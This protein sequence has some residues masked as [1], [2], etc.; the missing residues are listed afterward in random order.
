MANDTVPTTLKSS[1]EYKAFVTR[2]AVVKRKITLT[3]NQV[4]AEDSAYSFE[5]FISII[6]N[7]LLDIKALDEQINNLLCAFFEEDEDSEE[8]NTELDNQTKYHLSTNEKLNKLKAHVIDNSST[9]SVAGTVSDCNLKLPDLKCQCFSGEGTNELEFHSFI[10]QFNNVIGFRANL[11]NATKLT[12]LRTYLKGYALKTIQHLQ[13]CNANYSVV[14]DLL[15]KEFL[16]TNAL[17]D[18]LLKKFFELKPKSDS[19]FTEL[20]VFINEVRCILSDLKTYDYDCIASKPANKVVSHSVFHKLPVAFKQELVRKLGNNYPSITD[21]FENYVEVVRV[22]ELQS[23]PSVNSHAKSKCSS[24]VSSISKSSIV[25]DSSSKFAKFCKFCS[26]TGHSMLH[27]QK[28]STFL[29]RKRRCDE[30]NMCSKCSSQRHITSKCNSKLDYACTSCSSHDHI[31]ALC[32]RFAKVN[33]NFCVNSAS[34]AGRTFIL[35]TINVKLRHGKAVTSV[36]CLVD[37]GS[38]RSYISSEVLQRL[39]VSETLLNKTNLIINTFIDAASKQFSETSLSVTLH[40]NKTFLLPFLIN[41]DI[42]LS[43]TIHGL[44]QAHGNIAS[45]YN[46][47]E[48]EVNSDEVVLEGLLGV[49]ALQCLG[50]LKIVPCLGGSAFKV[51]NK[52]VPF[53]NVDNFL[54]SSQLASKYLANTVNNSVN[55]KL[56]VVKI[57][58]S[59][60]NFVVNPTKS[61]FDPI[62]SVI[63]DSAVE[64]SLDQLFSVE[65]LGITDNFCDYDQQQIDKFTEGITFKNNYYYVSLPWTEKLANVKSNFHVIRAILNKVVEKLHSSD[66]YDAYHEIIQQQ[67]TDGILEP[68]P[69][70]DSKLNEQVFIPHRPVIKYADQVTTKIRI[71][72]NCSL[73]VDSSPSLNEAAYKGVNLMGDLLQLLIKIRSND[74]LVMADVRQAFL[75][76]KLNSDFDK[77]KFTILWISPDGQLVSYRYTSLVFGF[78][79][80]PFILNHVIKY[81]VANYPPDDCSQILLSN[82]YVDNLFYTGHSYNELHELYTQCCERMAKGGFELRSWMSNHTEL[83]SDFVTDGKAVVHSCDYEKVLGY[84]YYPNTDQLALSDF[85]DDCNDV[86]I[87]KRSVLSYISRVFDP[88]GL[89]LPVTVMGK[90]FVQNLWKAKLSWDEILSPE[91]IKDWLK[92]K[93]ELDLLPQVKFA[94]KGYDQT[95]SSGVKLLICC[96]SSREV[97]GFSCY[98]KTETCSLPN[99]IFAKAKV[100]PLKTKTLPT[101]E[102]MAVY[103]GLRCLPSILSALCNRVRDVVFC[104]DAQIV[105]SWI[106]STYVKTKNVFAKNRVKDISDMRAEIRTNRN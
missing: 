95:D 2:R 66:I 73:K 28:Y 14:I 35:P 40:A 30:L 39:K 61:Y 17:T 88:M 106:L 37:T 93:S 59:I 90:I 38:Q 85:K 26:S 68:V 4:E 44:K 42:N 3:F 27:C 60:V 83:R 8:C 78:I 29:Q 34:D 62:G 57:D 98:A 63:T 56:S 36:R 84:N 53:G 7:H 49:D 20:K 32:N 89:V 33:S 5:N 41:D 70:L 82:L 81:H 104:V 23:R 97:Y 43:Y 6:E 45:K 91:L 94:S 21:I 51:I 80:S 22:L 13:I 87:S 31:S 47:H 69:L 99:L 16:D 75:M 74:Y 105:L 19:N 12:Y 10:S 67:L 65:S 58:S 18:D 64:D 52:F 50:E 72:L 96:D 86:A 76:I 46:Y 15:N 102:L 1:S 11:S 54:T 100:A 79:S 101:L 103:L 48:L 24:N 77:N 92:I 55:S 25:K 9:E 71:V